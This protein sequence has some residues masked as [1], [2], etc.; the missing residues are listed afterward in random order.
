MATPSIFFIGITGYIGSSVANRLLALETPFPITALTRSKD[1]A[2]LINN[3]RPHVKAVVGTLEDL[4]LLEEQASKHDITINTADADNLGATQAI[5]RGQAKRKEETGHRPILIH[6]SGTG[7]LTDNAQGRYPGMTIY[8]DL[9]PTNDSNPPLKGI[10]SLPDTQLHRNVDLAILAADRNSHIRSFII[11][12][13]TIYGLSKGELIDKGIGNNHSL[14]MPALI[15]ASIDRGQAG[16]VGEGKNI[17][18]NVHIHDVADLFIIVFKLALKGN[19]GNHG[20]QGYF[21]GESGEY[22]LFGAAEAIGQALVKR[23]VAKTALPSS[24]TQE[25]LDKYF[26]GSDYLGTNSRCRA[27][28]SRK[29]GWKPKYDGDDFFD[30]I[31]PEVEDVLRSKGPNGFDFGGKI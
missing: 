8:T 30:S 4:D 11:F 20:H 12:P 1:K 9:Y 2:E 13:S 22:T 29:V 5:L 26:G 16:M 21:F 6:T 23:G 18:P 28:R 14:Q 25:E 7:V 31:D 10:D 19:A 15:R 3:L 24:F 17:W 27:D